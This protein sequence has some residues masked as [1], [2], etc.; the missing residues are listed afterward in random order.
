[1]ERARVNLVCKF[2]FVKNLTNFPGEVA[3]RTMRTGTILNPDTPS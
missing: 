3:D 2:T 1:M